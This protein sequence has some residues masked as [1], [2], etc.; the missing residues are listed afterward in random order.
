MTDREEFPWEG[1]CADA[2]Y[3]FGLRCANLVARNPHDLAPLDFII[4]SLMPDLWNQNFSKRKI[5]TAF[6]KQ[7]KDMPRYAADEERRSSTSAE[8]A[9]ADWRRPE[10]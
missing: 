2:A 4:I 9:I 7:I 6:K 1:E 3:E 5:R 10:N 8:L